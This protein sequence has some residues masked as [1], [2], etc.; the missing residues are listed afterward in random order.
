MFQ[1]FL[2]HNTRDREWC[3]WLKASAE[4]T[5]VKAYL[6]EHDVQP[7]TNLAAKVVKAIE[8]SDAVVVLISDNSVAAPYVHQEIGYALKA[9]K[10]IIPLVQPG[11]RDES[12]AM[13]RGVEY[14]PFD[15]RHPHEG[16]QQL[17][18]ALGRLVEQQRRRERDAALIALACFG[19]ILLALGNE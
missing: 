13:L 1:I 19:V 5:G 15:F 2:S 16:H 14:I 11:I 3:E 7:G 9:G 17:R 6:A 10:V 8:A 18:K 4:E 12:L